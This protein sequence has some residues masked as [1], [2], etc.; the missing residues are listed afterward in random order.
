LRVA[1]SVNLKHSRSCVRRCREYKVE[2]YARAKVASGTGEHFWN[3]QTAETADHSIPYLV[4]VALIDGTVTLRSY[5]DPFEPCDAFA[6]SLSLHHI[7]TLERKTGLFRRAFEA[8]R[9]GGVLVNADATMPEDAADRQRLFRFWADHQVSHG[10]AE[11]DAWR[12]F[13]EWADQDTYMPL[14]VELAALR[15]VGFEAEQVWAAGPIGVV[16]ARKPA[17]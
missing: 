7:S 10:I 13:E 16:V 1:A 6:A 11:E 12:H 9:P 3:P 8:L 17:S 4:A 15:G 2:V 14:D 5:D